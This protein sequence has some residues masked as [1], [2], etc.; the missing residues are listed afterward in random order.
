MNKVNRKLRGKPIKLGFAV[1]VALILQACTG[2]EGGATEDPV[3]SYNEKQIKYLLSWPLYDSKV[4]SALDE[5]SVH[6]WSAYREE[7]H[8]LIAQKLKELATEH[9]DIKS[10]L[11]EFDPERYS[12]FFSMKDSYQ[13]YVSFLDEAPRWGR[14]KKNPKWPP[15]SSFESV[16]EYRARDDL[17]LPMKEFYETIGS[18]FQRTYAGAEVCQNFYQPNKQILELGRG[19]DGEQAL[20]KDLLF[21]VDK[22]ND[23]GRRLVFYVY[24]YGVDITGEQAKEAFE[25][26]GAQTKPGKKC[27]T[28]LIYGITERIRKYNTGHYL[29]ILPIKA[30]VGQDFYNV[31]EL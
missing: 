5:D 2:G 6:E 29:S 22:K 8:D 30:K 13:K 25:I 16:K 21:T 10:G 28:V 9:Y 23:N 27:M 18:L 20:G 1:V 4:W 26:Y 15:K 11:V 3:L 14:K 31:K 19:G 17:D 12:S 24:G 7:E